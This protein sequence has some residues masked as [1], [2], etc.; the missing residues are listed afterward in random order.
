MSSEL[1]RSLCNG[2]LPVTPFQVHSLIG[3]VSVTGT[4]GSPLACLAGGDG[5]EGG[6]CHGRH[7]S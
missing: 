5:T 7:S 3:Y 4:A 1:T 6:V 2:F